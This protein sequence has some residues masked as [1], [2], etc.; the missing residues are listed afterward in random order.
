MFFQTV[1]FPN[2]VSGLYGDHGGYVLLPDVTKEEMKSESGIPATVRDNFRFRVW[3]TGL[4]LVH[5]REF[6]ASTILCLY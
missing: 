2:I 6:V 3:V 4:C 5:V 1:I